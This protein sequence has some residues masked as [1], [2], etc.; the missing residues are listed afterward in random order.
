MRIRLTTLYS[1]GLLALLC[2]LPAAA[3][4]VAKVE[5][6]GEALIFHPVIEARALTLTV[7][8]P[9]DYRSES[10]SKRGEVVFKLDQETVDGRY[11][12]SLVATPV[13]DREVRRLLLEAREK[14]DDRAVRELCREGRLPDAKKMKQSGSFT[15]L[16][17]KIIFEASPESERESERDEGQ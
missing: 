7:A 10:T 1:V 15:V 13:L 6:A 11:D 2:A 8:G 5:N 16:E 3:D 17:G 14:G 9:C 4:A 12:Y